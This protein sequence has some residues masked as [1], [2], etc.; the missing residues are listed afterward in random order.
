MGVLHT[1]AL[2]PRLAPASALLKPTQATLQAER[3]QGMQP[4]WKEQRVQLMES[5]A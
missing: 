1:E 4:E 2:G 5:K 3:A